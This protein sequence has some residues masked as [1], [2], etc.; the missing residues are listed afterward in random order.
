MIDVKMIG[1]FE[2]MTDK[3]FVAWVTKQA[4]DFLAKMS[5]FE[6]Y[7]VYISQSIDSTDST[8]S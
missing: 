1:I 8:D 7:Q 5:T 2:L 3:N 6:A 4:D